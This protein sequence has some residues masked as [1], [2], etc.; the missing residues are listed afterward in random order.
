MSVCLFVC[1]SV[2]INLPIC[3]LAMLSIIGVSALEYLYLTLFSDLS[4]SFSHS[5]ALRMA[6]WVTDG[7]CANSGGG[8]GRSNQKDLAFDDFKGAVPLITMKIR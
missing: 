7:W 6:P 8:Q 4:S 1:L 3:V 5:G 2:S